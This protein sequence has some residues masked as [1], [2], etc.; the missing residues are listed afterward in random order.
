[1]GNRVSPRPDEVR[2]H[3]FIT[4]EDWIEMTTYERRNAKDRAW[5]RERGLGQTPQSTAGEYIREFKQDN[6][7]SRCD[8]D[9][10]ACLVFHHNNPEEKEFDVSRAASI[11]LDRVKKEVEKCTILCA[12][13]HRKLHAKEN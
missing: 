5:R 4:E 8:E 2:R 10:P 7:C 9:H 6:G 12:N 3:C 1:M 13:C 11:A